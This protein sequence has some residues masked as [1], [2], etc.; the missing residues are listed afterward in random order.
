M[1]SSPNLQ[2]CGREGTRGAV[3]PETASTARGGGRFGHGAGQ[4][5]A[6]RTAT[7]QP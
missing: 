7:L 4:F 3:L 6:P 2:G 5:G 1:M